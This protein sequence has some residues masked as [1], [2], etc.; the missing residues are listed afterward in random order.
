MSRDAAVSR[1]VE[2][3]RG[4]YAPALERLESLPPSER[5]ALLALLQ[6][7]TG[8]DPRYV[9]EKTLT[10]SGAEFADRLMQDRGLELA[11]Y[12]LRMTTK[13][14]NPETAWLPLTDPV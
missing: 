13:S 7:Y 2:W 5:A 11:L 10:I 6:R 8:I 14:R 3:A 9:D 12:D 1:A 4:E